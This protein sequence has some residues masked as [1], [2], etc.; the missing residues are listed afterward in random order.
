MKIELKLT[1]LQMNFLWRSCKVFKHQ[2]IPNE[3]ILSRMDVQTWFSLKTVVLQET[4]KS[5]IHVQVYLAYKNL[6]IPTGV[7]VGIYIIVTT[8]TH[9]III[10]KNNTIVTGKLPIEQI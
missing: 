7:E 2:H 9:V 1:A 6:R 4:E 5:Q 10:Y 3:E 8:N